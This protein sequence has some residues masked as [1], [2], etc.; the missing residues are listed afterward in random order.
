MS[1][2]V[3]G[4]VSV[5]SDDRIAVYHAGDIVE[6]KAG[7]EHSVEA[8]NDDAIWLCIHAVPDSELPFNEKNIDEVLIQEAA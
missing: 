6:I 7:V 4:W 1:V 5:L 3:S 2:V 8:L